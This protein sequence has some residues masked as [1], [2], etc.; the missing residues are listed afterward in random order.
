MIED[1]LLG[2]IQKAICIFN[3]P[4]NDLIYVI[5]ECRIY[6]CSIV[7]FLCVLVL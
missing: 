2:E 1:N 6:H 5:F 7:T 3:S 4:V